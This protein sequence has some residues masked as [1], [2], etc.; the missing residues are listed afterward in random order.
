MFATAG[1]RKNAKRRTT[2]SV[3]WREIVVPLEQDAAMKLNVKWDKMMN[4]FT[5]P[6]R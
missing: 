3:T 2:R 4:P 5:V 6:K 1:S